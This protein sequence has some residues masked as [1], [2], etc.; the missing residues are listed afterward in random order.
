MTDCY[1]E[2]R[3]ASAVAARLASL[4]AIT[5]GDRRAASALDLSEFDVTGTVGVSALKALRVCQR[6]RARVSAPLGRSAR[7]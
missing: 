7:V 5:R 4:G 1:A 6:G 3:F 2:N